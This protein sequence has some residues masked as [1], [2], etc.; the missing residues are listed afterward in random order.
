MVLIV[1]AGGE[2]AHPMWAKHLKEVL[3]DLDVQW[4]NDPKV[5][6]EAVL[7][8]LVFRPDHGRLAG[9]PNLR[10]IVSAGAG[11]DHLV[12]DPLRPRQIGIVR[13]ADE[14]TAQ[15]MGEYVCLGALALLRD[16]KRVV[17]QQATR[18]WK[19]FSQ[20]R[21]AN[22][23]RVGIMGLGNLGVRSAEM[24]GG[25]GF[26]VA[27]WS[28]SRKSIPGVQSFEGDAE[29]SAFLARTDILVNLL[30]GTPQTRGIL[31]RTTLALLPP[32]AAV[33]NAGRGQHIVLDDLL[34][35]LD[36]GQLSGAFLDVFDSE[37]I[38]ADH[39]AWQHPK[40]FVTPHIASMA[41]FRA[42]AHFAA[43]AIIAYEQGGVV[44]NLYDPERGY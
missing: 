39:P 33:I 13:M 25:L 27:G 23:T 37:P 21:S 30:P 6:P 20:S 26:P 19:N 1:N 15:R 36:T 8:A 16:L 4:W 32:G 40:V 29:F 2:I 3:P 17:S 12:S 44:P 34:T 7:Y 11:V 35:A 5:D 43:Q 24:L 22:E 14:E 9:F 28:Q 42:R 38:A 41:S 31:N 10:L 18:T